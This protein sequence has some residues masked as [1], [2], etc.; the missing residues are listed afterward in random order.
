MRDPTTAY[1]PVK[2]AVVQKRPNV[3]KRRISDGRQ[4]LMALPRRARTASGVTHYYTDIWEKP[5][6]DRERQ[7]AVI[8]YN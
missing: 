4:K 8:I 1:E 5:S 3:F 7:G 2:Q 6:P